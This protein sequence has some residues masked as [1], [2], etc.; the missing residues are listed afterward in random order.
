VSAHKSGIAGQVLTQRESRARYRRIV[1]FAARQL[2]STWWFEIVLPQFGF[3][4]ISR[5]T[6]TRRMQIIAR[7]FNALALELSGLMIKVGQFLSTRLDVLPAVITQELKELQDSVPPVAFEQLRPLIEQ[8]LGMPVERAFASVESDPLA[9]ASLG[10]AHRAVLNALDAELMGFASVVVKVQRPGIEQVVSVD[11][12]ALRRVATW[13]DRIRLVNTRADA[14]ALLEEFAATCMEE[15][16]YLTEGAHAERF[17]SNFADNLRVKVPA[18]VWERSSRKVLTL[19]DVSAIKITDLD[20]LAKV[21]IDPVDVADE[22]ARIMLDQVLI[23]GFFHAD[24]HPGNVFVEPLGGDD[25]TEG[26]VAWRLNFVDFGMMGQVSP[27]LMK[28]L[29]ATVIAAVA[30]DGIGFIS[31]LRDMGVLRDGAD[32]VELSRALNALFARFAGLSFADLKSIDEKEYRAFATEFSEIVLALPFQLPQN[33]LLVVRA[34]SFISGMCTSL[35]PEFN[36]WNAVEPYSA[37]IVRA[38]SGNFVEAFARDAW[39]SLR[40]VAQLPKRLDSLLTRIEDGQLVVRSP[41]VERR[42]SDVMRMVRRL[43]SAVMFCGLLIAGI[44]VYPSAPGWGIGI[45]VVS[46]APLIHA[47]FS[48]FIRR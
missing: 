9:A 36:I 40:T 37:K 43:I 23:D 7:R 11:L 45:F 2:V 6:R 33:F 27:G 47:L 4:W 41:E 34:L 26:A 12:D 30:Q 39:S 48:G 19:E 25:A 18:V 32:T 35:N 44:L 24:P 8:Q 28:A 15:I 14:P 10:Q 5:R 3:G 21:G 42:T 38:E 29:R 1:R 17:A 46:A 16:D 22:F 20:A 13:L 31:G